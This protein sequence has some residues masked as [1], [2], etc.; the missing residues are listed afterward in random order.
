VLWVS[1]L[2]VVYVQKMEFPGDRP[3][4]GSYDLGR[5]L[6]TLAS[7]SRGGETS[8]HTRTI[9]DAMAFRH[10]KVRDCMI[11]R[12]EIVAVELND[13]VAT[14]HQAFIQSGHSRVIVYRGTVDDILGYCPS[15]KLF[16]QPAR[17]ADIMVP[18]L[19]VP[20]TTLANDLMMRFIRERKS[21]ACVMDEFGGTSGIVSMEDIME[22]VFG[23]RGED[24]SHE[25]EQ[26]L[27]EQ[28]FLFNGR[29]EIRYINE[30]YK[31]QLPSGNYE[32]LGGLI[33]A[34]AAE[35]PRPGDVVV[36]SDFT[37]TVQSVHENRVGMVRVVKAIAGSGT[38]SQ[39]EPRQ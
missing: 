4:F 27:D 39:A 33:L 20:E 14:L 13:S 32:T 26:R 29:L 9:Q 19:T 12:T 36:V 6:K 23:D 18:M 15:G 35:F 31:L 10:I 24:H 1:K 38:A 21:M 28:T 22:E 37:L 8:S 5:Y 30:T 16:T 25:D 3:L 2:W 11:P 7:A 34:Y 17:I